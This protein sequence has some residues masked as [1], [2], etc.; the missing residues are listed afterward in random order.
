MEG[1]KEAPER[2]SSRIF[3][4]L[5]VL[6]DPIRCRILL[7]LE[8]HE[9]SVS[10]ICAVLQLPQSTISRHLK[11]LADDSWIRARREGTSRRY[12]AALDFGDPTAQNLWHLLREEISKGTAAL[13]DRTRLA[14]ILAQRRS[15][16]QEFFSTKAGD[17]TQ[18]RRDLFGARF[19]LE[20][21]LGLLDEAWV[22]ADLGCGTGQTSR[23]LAPFVR[24]VIA[25]DESEAML[26]AARARLAGTSNVEVRSGHLED[27]PIEAG[28]LD[29]ALAVLVLHHVPDPTRVLQEARRALKPGGKLL[30]VDM[31]PH[32]RE[33]YR[34][35][36]G[37][38]WLGFDELQL[39]LWLEQ[40]GFHH[41]TFHELRADP[42]AKGPTL[43][44][45]TARTATA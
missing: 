26:T 21:L 2:E 22:L 19:D 11:T 41:I 10:E 15:R 43:F 9:L 33:E 23:S 8:A 12:S 36:M 13:Q 35:Q 6:G 31:L 44:A 38:V 45:A 42:E 37:H 18:V 28:S 5:A 30:V 1:L 7:L 34:Q 14:G 39:R 4:R 24:R 17:W 20:S 27:L 25:I 3:D 16:S 40:A 29:A 32:E